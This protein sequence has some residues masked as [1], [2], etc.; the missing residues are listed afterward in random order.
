MNAKRFIVAFSSI[1]FLIS[2]FAINWQSDR[3]EFSF[4]AGFY[5]LAFICYLIIIA[6]RSQFQ[7]KHLLLIA[8]L[9]QIISILFVPHLSDDYF[10]FLWDGEM[11]WAGINPFDY[12]PEEIVNREFVQSSPYLQEV[13][14]GVSDLSKTHYSCYPPVNQGYFIFATAFSSSVIVNTI[15]LKMLIVVTEMLGAF[16]LFKTLTL[17]KID[18]SRMWI[19]YLNPLLIIECTGNVHFEGVMASFL[20]IGIFYLVQKK[21]LLGSLFFAFAIQIKLV[22]LL[23]LPFFYR[24]LGFWKAALF[25]VLTILIIVGL[26]F[27]QL[28]SN[29]IGNFIDSLKLYIGIFEFNSFIVHYVIQ[30]GIAEHGWKAGRILVPYVSQIAMFLIVALALYGDIPD[31]RKLFKRMTLA[32]FVYLILSN[33]MHP[34]YVIPLLGISLF[35]NYSFPILWSF[36][37]FFSYIFYFFD[38]RSVTEVRIM[39]NI[40]YILLLT[41]VGYELIKKKSPLKFLHLNNFLQKESN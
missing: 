36:L 19:L 38:D 2:L 5:T 11:T 3:T 20:F 27:V 28:N 37:I 12:K 40:E 39:I 31:W 15:T 22:P 7:F 25:Y 23:L 9:A 6:G 18:T 29:N 35:T 26:G 1:L 10:R 16:F 14:Q 30:F 21:E 17:L 41:L 8:I 4:V 24:F 33:T 32:F 34:W 13:Y